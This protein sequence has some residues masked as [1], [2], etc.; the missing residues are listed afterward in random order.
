MNLFDTDRVIAVYVKK[1]IIDVHSL[2]FEYMKYIGGQHHIHCEVHKIPLIYSHN[3][4][5]KCNCGRK[6]TYSC[7]SLNCPT[8]ICQRCVDQLDA[9]SIHFIQINMFVT[10]FSFFHKKF[11]LLIRNWSYIQMKLYKMHFEP[12]FYCQDNL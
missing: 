6:E 7:A 12:N 10:L 3:R 2:N 11:M 1:K 4:S 5:K 9:S 8:C